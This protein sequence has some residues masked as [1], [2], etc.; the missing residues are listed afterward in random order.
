MDVTPLIQD[1]TAFVCLFA[2]PHPVLDGFPG[3]ADLV[4]QHAGRHLAVRN[5]RLHKSGDTLLGPEV[6]LGNDGVALL[7]G[8][9]QVTDVPRGDGEDG[10]RSDDADGDGHG[11]TEQD[12]AVAGDDAAGHGRDEDVDGAGHDLLARLL[13]RSQ[14]RD[15]A[16]ERVLQAQGLGQPRVDLVLGL[17]SIS[18]QEQAGLGNL[19]GQTVGV[20]GRRRLGGGLG[21]ADGLG[22]H[23]RKVVVDGLAEVLGRG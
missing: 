17:G 22:G 5:A 9:E 15:G 4:L 20:G 12:V 13:G 7:V 6:V 8:P 3:L 1:F 21:W 19:S 18:V 10:P 2:L 14:R 16:G 23:R 11:R